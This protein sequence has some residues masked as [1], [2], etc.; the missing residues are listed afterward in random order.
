M[1]IITLT[2]LTP[3]AIAAVAAEAVTILAAGGTVIYPT[4]TVY[5]IG[6]DAT[7]PQAVTKVLTYKSRREG[8]PLSIAVT[9]RQMAE[10]FVAASDQARELYERFLPGPVTVV[11]KDLGKVAPG[12]ASEFGTLG[13]RISSHPLVAAMV[14][15]LQKP[16]TATS[17]NASGKKR[18]YTLEDIFSRL[19]AKQLDLI[20]LAIDA[21]TLPPNQPSTVIDT[22]LATPLIMRQGDIQTTTEQTKIA[23]YTTHQAIETR[24][25]AGKLL[26]KYWESVKQTGLVIGLNG[27]LGAG[28]TVLTQGIGQFLHI[29]EPIVSPTYNYILEYSYQRFE[30]TG[31]L[32]HVDA[33]KIDSRADFEPLHLPKLVKPGTVLVIEWWS[34]VA[35]LLLPELSNSVPVITID[36]TV[37]GETQ[38][39]LIVHDVKEP[40]D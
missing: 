16:I 4:E 30:Q 19:S 8:K 24:D 36:L 7:N 15:Q 1:R 32:Q 38:R 18:P 25:L 9:D 35:D 11:S 5:G 27:N 6:V 20:D 10:K 26:L 40:H 37:T 13:I 3:K 33:W 2:D 39:E 12:V 23:T 22:T 34:Q 21:G 29:K 14:A 31:Q 28:K 17:A